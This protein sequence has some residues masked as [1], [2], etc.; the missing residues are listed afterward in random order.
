MKRSWDAPEQSRCCQQRNSSLLK[1]LINYRRGQ[2]GPTDAPPC[3]QISFLDSRT[4]LPEIPLCQTPFLASKRSVV[5]PSFHTMGGW[6]QSYSDLPRATRVVR[7]EPQAT[8]P[9]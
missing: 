4:L 3:F 7:A 9:L 2:S 1:G 5:G 6:R 8:P